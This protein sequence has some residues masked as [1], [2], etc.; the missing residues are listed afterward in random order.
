MTARSDHVRP[1]SLA[2]AGALT[3]G[4]A[5]AGA[6]ES[7]QQSAQQN[8]PRLEEIVVTATRRAEDLT[9]VPMS[10]TAFSTHDMDR[11]DIQDMSDIARYTPGVTFDSSG[12]SN[13]ISI[14]GISSNVGFATTAVYIDDTA[15]PMRSNNL[16]STGTAFPYVFDLDRVEVLRGPQG[17]LFGAGAEGGAI[18]FITP[19]PSLSTYSL[20]SQA[21]A[22][23]TDYGSPSYQAGIA[24]GGPLVPGEVGGRVSLFYRNDGGYIDHQSILPGGVDTPDSNSDDT[25]VGR[26]ALTIAPTGALRIT[27]SVFFQDYHINDADTFNDPFSNPSAG[28]FRNQNVLRTPRT[29]RFMLPAL[30]IELRLPQATFI[31]LSSY[32]DRSNP[33][34]IDYT[35]IIP[36]LLGLSPYPTGP[37]QQALTQVDTS[38]DV[39]TQE[40]RLQSPDSSD[41]LRWTVGTYF[42]RDRL[43]TFE[44][45]YQPYLATLIQNLTGLSLEQV[46]GI[47]LIDGGYEFEGRVVSYDTQTAGYGQVDYRLF[48]RFTLTAGVRVSRTKFDFNEY[49]EGVFAG[50]YQ[51]QSGSQSQTPVTPKFVASYQMNPNNLFY[52]SVAK[53]FRMGGVNAPIAATPGCTAEL[54]ALGLGSAPPTFNSDTTWS[55]EVGAKDTLLDHKLRIATSLYHIDWLGIQQSVYLPECGQGFV[56]NLGSATSNGADFSLT[57]VVGQHLILSLALGYDDAEYNQTVASGPVILAKKGEALTDQA[58]WM[59]TVAADYTFAVWGEKEAYLHGDFQHT[60]HY[61]HM[62]PGTYSY[63]PALVLT[64]QPR[65]QQLNL[66]TGLRWAGWDLSLY[67]NNVFNDFPILDYEHTTAASPLFDQTTLRPR[68]IGITAYYRY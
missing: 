18:R 10:V 49:Q 33:N 4:N 39:I 37:G 52:A 46:F 63:D 13:N 7:S 60:D 20:Y 41:P 62:T 1:L 58:P 67:A 6:Q 68:T 59:G 8:G 47:G 42:S 36:A 35:E 34:V 24:A 65:N 51:V 14:R 54:G 40:F 17:T 23:F 32:F 27:P 43:D 64:N 56:G 66:R 55:Y 3:L 50:G 26:A 21:Q 5:I 29:D 22:G 48:N 19:Q 25:I 2:L 30:R 9:K 57:G 12:A 61:P 44:S 31:S 53:G 16:Y 28:Y 15:V 11:L 38:Q 45:A